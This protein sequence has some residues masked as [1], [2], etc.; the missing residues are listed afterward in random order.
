MNHR[1]LKHTAVLATFSLLALP[2]M[3]NSLVAC[4]SVR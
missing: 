2:A 4:A 1:Y 3:A